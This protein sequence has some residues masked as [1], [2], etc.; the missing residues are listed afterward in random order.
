VVKDDLC[1]GLEVEKLVATLPD[2]GIILLENVRF[3]KEEENND[4]PF[5]KKELNYL[6]GAVLNPKRP[7]AAIV[8]EVVEVL[9]DLQLCQAIVTKKYNVGAGG[10]VS[11]GVSQGLS[12]NSYRKNATVGRFGSSR[13]YVGSKSIGYAG[14]SG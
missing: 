5:A 13:G 6:D 10:S 8:L 7:F 14:G 4:P 1:I 11:Y 2:S 3:Y 12:S 9:A